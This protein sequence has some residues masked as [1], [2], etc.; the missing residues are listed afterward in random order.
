MANDTLWRAFCRIG[1]LQDIVD[2]PRFRTNA[3]RVTHRAETVARVREVLKARPRDEWIAL[4]GDAGIPCSP[5]HTLGELSAHPHTVA[6]GMV[7]TIDDPRYGPLRTVSQPLRFDGE[8]TAIRRS[9]P[10]HGADGRAVLADAGFSADQIAALAAAGAVR[11]PT[12]TPDRPEESP[13]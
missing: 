7:R 4:L 1:G 13:T 2:D 5:L 8:R 12:T 9:P 6:S 11:L 3:D 10:A